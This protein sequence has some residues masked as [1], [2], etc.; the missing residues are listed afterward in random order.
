MSFTLGAGNLAIATL[1]AIPIA[2]PDVISTSDIARR[3][4]KTEL[5]LSKAST[6]Y[7]PVE[8]PH[9]WPTCFG[10]FAS[11]FAPSPRVPARWMRGPSQ[12]AE[13]EHFKCRNS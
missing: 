10:Q 7:G 4:N 8:F 2:C 3:L 1:I 12:M 9:R 13:L 11:T 5:W 6:T